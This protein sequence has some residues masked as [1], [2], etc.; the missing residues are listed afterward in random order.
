MGWYPKD[1]W[2]SPTPITPVRA[3]SLTTGF[4]VYGGVTQKKLIVDADATVS[5]L[6]ASGHTQNT[7]TDL[8]ALNAKNPPI[9]ADKVVYRDSTA[10]DALVTSTW[11]QVKAFLK[12]YFDTLYNK[13]VHP[14]HSGDVT[15]TADGAQV[16]VNMAGKYI[17]RADGTDVPIADGG[18]GQGTAQLAINSLSA[19]AGATNEHVL[20]KDTA[21][22]NAIFKNGTTYASAAEILTGTEAAKAIA[23]DTL[24]YINPVVSMFRTTD[25]N[26]S[27][28][29]GVW[30]VL[31]P[32]A[33]ELD[34][35]S[36]TT[37]GLQEAINY[38]CR[39]GYDLHV[40]GGTY[41]P[42]S[43]PGPYTPGEGTDVSI[44]YLAAAITIPAVEKL[45]FRIDAL[46]IIF[47]PSV[48]GNAITFD[49]GVMIDFEM[50]GGQIGYSGDNAAVRIYPA[51]PLPYSSTG[52]GMANCR[53]IFSAIALYGDWG[54]T[55]KGLIF[56]TSVAGIQNSIF[57][58]FEVNFGY[59][60]IFVDAQHGF[61]GNIVKCS[62]V[63]Q[64][65]G[66]C[67]GL[68]ND[69]TNGAGCRGNR[70]DLTCSPGNGGSGIDIFG[71][72]NIIDICVSNDEGTC[73][74]AIVLEASAQRNIIT[75]ARLEGSTKV[76]DNSTYRNNVIHYGASSMVLPAFLAFASAAQ[77][78][79]DANALTTIVF[80]TEVFD[81]TGSF[82]SNVFTA[83]VTGK[84]LLSTAVSFLAITATHTDARLTITTSNRTYYHYFNPSQLEANASYGEGT[85]HISV[86]AD[87][88]VGDTAV[89]KF[90]FVQGSDHDIDIKYEA[91]GAA[92]YTYF[93]GHLVC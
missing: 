36:S 82:A 9:D 50:K 27:G 40:H 48:K 22:G 52:P 81:Q 57:E 93:S 58:A 23:P 20:T 15:S 3:K 24:T 72:D 51:N 80:G 4:E 6:V 91:T 68:D 14:N 45:V 28:Q 32:K 42:G 77:D 35:S 69:A 79:I 1:P 13:Y 84:Y 85:V 60:G 5:E 61:A 92:M 44:L 62:G 7:D 2:E 73:N 21:T 66:F 75:C 37:D 76:N 53:F 89:V 31:V 11:T 19:V 55:A 38:A 70:F 17:Y 29:N 59:Y 41:K 78:D 34:I 18:T 43:W 65:T 87:M 25:T 67:V 46:S 10:S 90:Q 86:L 64:Q 16:I 56:D 26:N 33:G 39:Y 12:T 47:A 63:H 49:S 88:D 71:T 54:A 30:H 8:G 74:T 83:P